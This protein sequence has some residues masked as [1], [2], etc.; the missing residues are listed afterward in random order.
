MPIH[1]GASRVKSRYRGDTK[2]VASYR[3]GQRI[4][5][6]VNPATLGA[7]YWLR[8]NDVDPLVDSGANP[9]TWSASSPPATDGGALVAGTVNGS[10]EAIRPTGS[11]WSIAG[12]VYAVPGRTSSINAFSLSGTNTATAVDLTTS[13]KA[14]WRYRRGANSQQNPSAGATP[15]GWAHYAT[16]LEPVSGTNWRF[17]GYINGQEIVNNLFNGGTQGA[18]SYAGIAVISAGHQYIDDLVVFD[19]AISQAEVQALVAL[20]RGL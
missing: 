18:I 10:N 3:G 17:R 12:W 8:F 7:R 15:T 11:G 13:G 14:T 19:R 4:Y 1:R 9:R 6:S 20:G 16:C 2:I 5:S